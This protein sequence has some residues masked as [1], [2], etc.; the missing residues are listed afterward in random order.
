MARVNIK[1]RDLS[2]RF[3]NSDT[4][5][6]L[7]GLRRQVK[8]AKNLRSSG[9]ESRVHANDFLLYHDELDTRDS[10]WQKLTYLA[11]SKTRLVYDVDVSYHLYVRFLICGALER[12][13]PET[14]PRT[15]TRSIILD[16]VDMSRL[17]RQYTEDCESV[18]PNV[19]KLIA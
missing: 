11:L 10:Q 16:T 18:L 14:V 12:R 3:T 15:L 4:G 7:N 5:Y 19:P 17:V 6:I 9:T 13:G 1:E 2:I 8:I